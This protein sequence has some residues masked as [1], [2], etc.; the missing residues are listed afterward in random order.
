MRAN[1]DALRP[2]LHLDVLKG[3]L[4]DNGLARVVSPAV[5]GRSLRTKV[6]IIEDAR[7]AYGLPPLSVVDPTSLG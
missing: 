4:R 2:A 3:A 1:V 7:R 5:G 6:H